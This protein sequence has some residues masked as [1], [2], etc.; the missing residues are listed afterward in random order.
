MKWHW[1]ML[2]ALAAALA[3]SIACGCGDDDDDDNDDEDDDAADDDASSDDD[4]HAADDDLDDD[5][6]DDAPEVTPYPE[7][8]E[9]DP[10]FPFDLFDEPYA[11]PYPNN[12]YT[13]AD[14]SSPTGLRVNIDGQT[15]APV[16]G[17]VRGLPFL[18]DAIN[19]LDG[20]STA[21]DLYV[22]VDDEPD[23][24][25]YPDK[26]APAADDSVRLVVSDP[27]DPH[28]GEQVA[29]N[30]SWHKG[31]L[32]AQPW[33][34]LR[35]RTRYL[36]IVTRGFGRPGAGCYRASETMR[37]L[38]WHFMDGRTSNWTGTAL[39]KTMEGF[40]DLGIDAADVLS[41]SGIHD[42]IHHPGHG[43]D[44]RHAGR[45]GRGHAAG[46][47][48]LGLYAERATRARRHRARQAAGAGLSQR[49]RPLGAGRGKGRIQGAG[50]DRAGSHSDAARRDGHDQNAAV[51]G[52]FLGPRDLE[53]PQRGHQLRQ[54]HRARRLCR[55]VRRRGL[56]RRART[57]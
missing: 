53:Q 11:V 29:L 49:A 9:D 48:R 14:G 45:A 46:V 42:A 33:T 57:G 12:I 30:V 16:G 50:L 4:T 25:T 23:R 27:D 10:V 47:L 55:P 6:D 54:P 36:L 37:R 13:V 3:G 38:W 51:S 17:T 5:A 28:Y 24:L 32:W 56:P 22:R 44:A 18:R 21:G 41:F 43:H 39:L 20:F 7:T 34:P 15:T 8:C 26:S 31:V 1:L 2:A 19:T 40:A 35:E 52:D